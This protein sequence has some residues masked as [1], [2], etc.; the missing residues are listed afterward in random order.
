MAAKKDVDSITHFRINC[1][2]RLNLRKSIRR[3]YESQFAQRFSALKTDSDVHEMRHYIKTY[4]QNVE[5]RINKFI[6]MYEN[7]CDEQFFNIQG[8]VLEAIKHQILEL[9]AELKPKYDKIILIFSKRKNENRNLRSS[10]YRLQEQRNSLANIWITKEMLEMQRKAIALPITTI[11]F[12]SV[13]HRENDLFNVGEL[14]PE[15]WNRYRFYEQHLS[16]DE[17]LQERLHEFFNEISTFYHNT[18][19]KEIREELTAY[20]VIINDQFQR[21]WSLA[22]ENDFGFRAYPK[23]ALSIL[24]KVELKIRKRAHTQN[25]RSL[26]AR[27]TQE[28]RSVAK[29]ERARHNYTAQT[30][31]YRSC[32]YCAGA[33]GDFEGENCSELDHIHPISKGGLSTPQNLIFICSNCNRKKQ[34][35]TLNKFISEHGLDRDKIFTILSRLGKDF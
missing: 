28:Q 26:A 5:P 27:N 6:R 8:P 23:I 3:E 32:P 14:S 12:P 35:K 7:W 30:N 34:A 25:L 24:D 20:N 16:P 17:D 10:I 31:V 22:Y 11:N 19:F 9:E 15:F 18:T 29:V 21:G 13:K 1:G 4:A 2:G 33:L